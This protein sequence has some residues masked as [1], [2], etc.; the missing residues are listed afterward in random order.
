MRSQRS[1]VALALLCAVAAATAAQTHQ[2]PENVIH[3]RQSVMDL[4]GWN[5]A[6]LGE[7]VKGRMPWDAKEFALRTERLETLAPQIAEGFT[8][9]SDTGAETD[10]KP[11]IWTDFEDFQAKIDDYV[12]EAKALNEA[13]KSGDETKMR[14]QFRKTAAACKA[15]HEKYKA[16]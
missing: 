13:A 14:E 11:E 1:H 7:M 8:R 6:P 10:A 3:Y 5:F 16:D 12:I 4:M 15:C 9:G 2:K